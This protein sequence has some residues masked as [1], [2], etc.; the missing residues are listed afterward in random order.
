MW[1]IPIVAVL[2]IALVVLL[3]RF[4]ASLD[5]HR[6]IKGLR[7][8][9]RHLGGRMRTLRRFPSFSSNRASKYDLLV[10]KDGVLYAVKLW[11]CARRNTDLRIFAD[12][13]VCEERSEQAPL[14]PYGS[15]KQRTRRYPR[16]Y[17]RKTERNFR[18]PPKRELVCV[19]LVYPSYRR[20]II[21]KNGE[22]LELKS[23]DMLFDKILLSPTAFLRM[24][25]E[26]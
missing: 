4:L 1:M 24:L 9:L 6:A 17:V 10:E 3:P 21:E 19:L 22:A 2:L 16:A 5:R 18:L 11:S 14:T 26:K 25:S 15:V 12:G 7:V 23:G 8:K 20:I 13:R